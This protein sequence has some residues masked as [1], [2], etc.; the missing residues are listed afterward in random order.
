MAEKKHGCFPFTA[1]ISEPPTPE[2]VKTLLAKK[3]VS[4]IGAAKYFNWTGGATRRM[5]TYAS[6]RSEM[7]PELWE[8]TLLLAG[9]HPHYRLSI[10]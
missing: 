9:E 10:R 8:L 7:S 4:Q 5:A 2:E 3:D 6:G 1:Y